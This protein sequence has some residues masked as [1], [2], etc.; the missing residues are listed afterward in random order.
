MFSNRKTSGSNEKGSLISRSGASFRSELE[1][2]QTVPKAAQRP[3]SAS[4]PGSSTRVPEKET[5][6]TAKSSILP[7]GVEQP[8]RNTQKKRVYTGVE[9]SEKKKMRWAIDT[10]SDDD[11]ED[12]DEKERAGEI[13]NE[14]A[15]ATCEAI[16]KQIAGEEYKKDETTESSGTEQVGHQEPTV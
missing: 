5:T 1:E 15:G 3:R 12:D 16:M 10:S 8:M 7:T 2:N 4:T 14:Q 6:S 9:G 13:S 11:S